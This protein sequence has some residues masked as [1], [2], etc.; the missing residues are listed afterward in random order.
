[1]TP[2]DTLNLEAGKTYRLVLDLTG[3]DVDFLYK[4]TQRGWPVL[5]FG[6]ANSGDIENFENAQRVLGVL[7]HAVKFSAYAERLGTQTKAGIVENPVPVIGYLMQRVKDLSEALREA[8]TYAA[9]QEEYDTRTGEP[10]LA[11]ISAG[12]KEKWFN[13]MLNAER[14]YGFVKGELEDLTRKR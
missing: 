1:M 4:A 10:A 9:S 11:A 5:S 2:I 3:A 7:F 12:F 6:P 14:S 8:V 13:L